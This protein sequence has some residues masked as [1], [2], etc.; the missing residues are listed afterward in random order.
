MNLGALSGSYFFAY[1]CGMK[2]DLGKPLAPTVFSSPSNPS[3]SQ[4]NA[5]DK[6]RKTGI[7]NSRARFDGAGVISKKIYAVDNNPRLN[8]RVEKGYEK[9]AKKVEKA[10]GN[11]E[12]LQKINKKYGYDYESAIAGGATPDSTNH[13]PSIDPGSGKILKG[14]K[15]P[16]MIK[17][18]KVEKIL[19]N[20]IVKKKGSLYSVPKRK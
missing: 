8:K 3:K 12:K 10:K 14:S 4:Y 1:I 9:V 13:W 16:S 7:E 15:H 19:G 18:K 2:R 17:T 5:V 20:K 11:P 6:M